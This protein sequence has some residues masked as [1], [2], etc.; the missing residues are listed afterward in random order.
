MSYGDER[1]TR[2]GPSAAPS[3]SLTSSPH[4]VPNRTGTMGTTKQHVRDVLEPAS[5][6]ARASRA[7]DIF[8][9]S[10]I[11]LNVLAVVL[12]TVEGIHE[13][14]DTFLFWFEVVSVAIFTVEYVLRIWSCTA[15]AGFGAPLAGRLRYA[16]RPMMLVDL[17]A[18]LP[19]Y[20][21]MLPID[22]RFM[23]ALRLLRIVRLL[24]LNRYSVA[25]RT[26]TQV[27]LAKKEELVITLM[28]L[29]VLLLIA[30]SL[31]YYAEHEAQPDAFSSIPAAMW[32]GVAALTTVGYGDVYP[33]TPL[34]RMLA[35]FI[36]ILGIGMFALPAGILGGGFA[37]QISKR[38]DKGDES[39]A[40]DDDA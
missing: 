14:A 24:R 9:I 2:S 11:S 18:I 38:P 34:G 39:R 8:I 6:G 33:V 31:M 28:A 21:T 4:C 35:S 32:W 5:E 36:A 29:L 1:N 26:L 40:Q 20:L 30:S 3:V 13:S 10:L 22:L 25:L 12:E 27:L 15:L 16:I 17:L 37:E 19:A 7:F 23:R